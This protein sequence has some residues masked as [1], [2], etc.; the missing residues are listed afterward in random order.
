MMSFNPVFSCVG[1]LY[2][3]K[4]ASTLLEGKIENVRQATTCCHESLHTFLTYEIF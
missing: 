1:D 2:S 3:D 4:L